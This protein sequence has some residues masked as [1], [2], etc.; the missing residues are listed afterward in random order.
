MDKKKYNRLHYSL[1]SKHGNAIKCEFKD[2]CNG[3]SKTF[4]WALKKGRK[5]SDNPDDY[6]Q[7]CKSCHAKYDYKGG[8]IIS[9]EHKEK[10]RKIRTGL[11]P[12]NKGIDSR[13]TKTCKFCKSSYKA[14]KGKNKK[15]CS[16]LCRNEDMK[17]KPT[18]NKKGKNGRN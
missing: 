12:A 11:P 5:Y 6:Y 18:R 9:E 17:G 2:T 8:I 15:Y 14:Y 16:I 10:L 1:R 7:L 4:E 3:K 13:L